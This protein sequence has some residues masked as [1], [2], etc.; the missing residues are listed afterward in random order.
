MHNSWTNDAYWDNNINRKV[1]DSIYVLLNIQN[2]SANKL[3]NTDTSG[4]IRFLL[5]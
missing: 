4:E 3:Q 5:K 1:K 2:V